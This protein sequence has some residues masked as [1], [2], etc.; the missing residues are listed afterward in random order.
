MFRHLYTVQQIRKKLRE[1]FQRD[2][3]LSAI[4]YVAQKLGFQFMRIGMKRGYDISAYYELAQHFNELVEYDVNKSVKPRQT[5]QKQPSLGDYYTYNGEKDNVDYDW[6]K[7][8]GEGRIR[9]AIMESIEELDL[10]HGSPH[11]FQEFDLA[12][13]SSG[14]GQQAYGYGVPNYYLKN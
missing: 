12:F 3:S 8:L 4:H 6:E 9:K 1:R 7:K 5:T 11:E 14:W 10:Y 2:V 13:L